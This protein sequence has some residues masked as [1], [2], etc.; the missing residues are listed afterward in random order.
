MEESDFSATAYDRVYDAERPEIFF[1]CL[2]AE[3]RA[4]HGDSRSASAATRAGTCPSRNWRSSS[5]SR[6]RIVG[7]TIGNDMSS[8]DIE[9]E[10]LLYLPQAKIYDRSCALG[11]VDHLGAAETDAR[12]W[13]IRLGMRRGAAPRSFRGETPSRR[14][15]AASRSWASSCSAARSSPTA[16]CCSRAPASCRRIRSRCRRR[17]CVDIR[18]L[19]HRHADESGRAGVWWIGV[20]VFITCFSEVPGALRARQLASRRAIRRP[21]SRCRASTRSARGPTATPRSRRPPDAAEALRRAARSD[22]RIPERFADRIDA[23]KAEMAELAHPESGLPDSP[24]LADVELPRTTDQLRQAARGRAR[25]IVGAADDRHE[26]QHPL[27]PRADRAGRRLRA[28]QLSVRV[29]QRGRRRLRRGDRRRQPG[30]R[31]GPTR[32]PGHDAAARRGGVRRRRGDRPA[33]G[34]RAADLPHRSASRD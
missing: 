4:R 30:H 34:D 29:Q 28:E 20:H 23:R 8:R 22:C 17:T 5:T 7:C 12:G 13:T 32:S 6:G 1:K 10:N 16:P 21:A 25:G 31:Q 26:A 2:P 19:R 11:P 3:G 33:A 15:N 27:G 9:G 14:S 24:R 18:H